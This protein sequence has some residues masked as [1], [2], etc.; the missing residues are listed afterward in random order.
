MKSVITQK[1]YE[2][3]EHQKFLEDL[4]QFNDAP[5][6]DRQEARADLANDM[7]NC[8]DLIAE[9]VSWLLNGSY[10]F[11]SYAVSKVVAQN[12]RMNRAA[13]MVQ[14]IAA[15][16]WQCPQ[17]FAIVAFKGLDAKQQDR[18]NDLVMDQVHGHLS[19]MA[20]EGNKVYK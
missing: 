11:G 17:S 7:R 16:E 2:V 19:E 1:Q 18:L 6:K 13:W 4:N 20:A 3:R 8:P 10:G 12:K 5:L 15:L 14:T 9:R